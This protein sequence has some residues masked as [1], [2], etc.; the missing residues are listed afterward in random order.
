MSIQVK[1]RRSFFAPIAMSD[2]AFLLL[3]F[4]VVTASFKEDADISP[5]DFAYARKISTPETE[6]LTLLDDRTVLVSGV[7]I[8]L[9]GFLRALEGDAST[10]YEVVA[11][12]SLDYAVVDELLSA[13]KSSGRRQIVL[14]TEAGP[15]GEAGP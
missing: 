4:L 13:L 15:A 9:S 1:K 6:T 5:P 11:D 10:V 3:I 8:P 14:R 2:I 7:T 12:G